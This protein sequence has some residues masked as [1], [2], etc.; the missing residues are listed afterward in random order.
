MWIFFS[1]QDIRQTKSD[2]IYVYLHSKST[3]LRQ[4]SMHSCLDPT[5]PLLRI[6]NTLFITSPS[7]SEF[8]TDLGVQLVVH[9][10]LEAP[11]GGAAGGGGEAVLLDVDCEDRVLGLGQLAW[12]KSL[13][14]SSHWFCLLLFSSAEEEKRTQR[15]V[16]KLIDLQDEF[17]LQVSIQSLSI[18]VPGWL[19]SI[20][21]GAVYT[22]P[23][24][25]QIKT[26]IF[27][28]SEKTHQ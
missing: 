1:S 28:L 4:S 27:I 13:Q 5:C 10:S 21:W 15:P 26:L 20:S 2:G 9:H 16:S 8:A 7:G 3:S 6:W 11:G 12:H 22:N 24:N 25:N 23:G 18:R 17:C 19:S 14:S